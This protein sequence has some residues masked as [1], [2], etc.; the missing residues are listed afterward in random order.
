MM[1]LPRFSVN[2]PV[3]VNLFMLTIL[4]GGVYSGLTLV[5]ELFPEARPN[6][7]VITTLYPGAS[8]SEV[9]DGI[10]LKIEEQIKDVDGVDK[11]ESTISE[12]QSTISVELMSGFRNVDQAVEDI[13]SAIDAIPR[14]DFPEEALETRVAKFDVMLPVITVSLYGVD[15]DRT[16]KELG[17]RLRDEI[18]AL[19]GISDVVLTGTRKD[20]ISVEV[21]PEKLVEFGLSFMDVAEAIAD[22]NLDLPGGQIRTAGANVAV[23]TLGEKKKGEDLY[24]VVLRSDPT[25]R[26]IALRDV[27][28]IIDGFE[29]VDLVGRFQALP[30]VSVIVSKTADQDAIDIAKKVRALIAG[31]MG[32]PLVRTWTER[33]FARLT[34]NDT[35]VE[36]YENAARNPYPSGVKL[37]AHRDLSRFIEGRLDLL[38]RNGTWGLLFVFVS[39]L[40]FLHWRVALWVM[41]GLVLA[42]TGALVCMNLLGL[43]LN[44]ITAFGL[45]MM[46]GLLVDDA[47]IVSEHV[48]SKVEQG[49]SPKLAAITGTEEVTWPVVCAIVTTIVAFAPLAWIEGQMGDWLGVLPVIACV[50]LSVSLIEALTIL[51]CHLA[52]GVR[53]IKSGSPLPHG[54]G[55][56]RRL[57][58][59]MRVAQEYWVQTKL[60]VWYEGVLR[61]ATSYRYVTMAALTSI[62]III[63]TAVAAGH[64]PFVFL[65]KMDSDTLFAYMKMDVSTPIEKTVDA[66][67]VIEAAILD[68]EEV[69]SF[70]SLIGSQVAMDGMMSA[71]QAHLAQLF[72][73][74]HPAEQ[75]ERSSFQILDELRRKTSDIPGVEKLTFS[76]VHG[77]PGGAAIQIEISGG[78]LDDLIAVSRRLKEILAGFEGVT[79]IVDDFDGGRREV[80]IELLESARALGLTTRSLATQ[81]RAAFYGFEARKV[82]RGREDVKI[83][84]RY[85]R[86]YR[87]HIYDIEA[88][89]LAVPGSADRDATIR[90]RGLTQRRPSGSAGRSATQLVPFT[91]VAR[92]TEGTGYATIR[93]QNQRRTVTVTADVD[94][95][96][97]NADKVMG[98]LSEREFPIIVREHPGIQLEFGGQRLETLKS[99]SSLKH[100][101]VIALALIYVILAGLFRSYIQPVIVMAVIPFGLIGAVIGHFVMGYP[102][103]IMSM[104]GIVALSGIVVNDSMILV[105]FINRRVRAGS[106]A[107][108]AVIEGGKSRLRPILLTSATTVLGLA[109]LVLEQ[110]FQ[111][112]FLI[113]MG[114]SISAGLIFATVLTL[115]AVPSMY[116]I[117]LDAKRLLRATGSWL[118]VVPSARPAPESLL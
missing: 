6:R 89:R 65:Q 59:R 99:F 66:A 54:R 41:M 50:A 110:S 14:E 17:N 92:L 42:V 96:V 21:R 98:I 52:H 2:N 3:L 101:F 73:E 78:A 11:I 72:I 51:P 116:L 19:P 93:R 71:P 56:V 62:L 84:V 24:D 15:D 55:P 5:R 49:V 82:Q 109:P 103:T 106:P 104:F 108:E 22:S 45:I 111:A 37:T 60:R 12:G 105:T 33:L 88:M 63:G 80:Q 87:R 38:K 18:L 10:T 43:T 70:Y 83:M 68:L 102:L 112:K 13:K 76:A 95:T 9:E 25:G 1:S 118:G 47:I 34:G 114:I 8:P 77:G 79:E 69:Q 30:A 32:Q 46:L 67:G 27:A 7:V 36:V 81:V 74:L 117:V 20:E 31:K 44:L 86:R 75:R 113:P 107:V 35:V 58:H 94:M 16:L 4:V 115:V 97:T 90:E 28:T 40:V 100:S 23:R 61:L 91:E 64:V 57:V 48:Y 53:P 39:L 26:V 85:P 29:D